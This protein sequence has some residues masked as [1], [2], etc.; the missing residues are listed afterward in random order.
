MAD[1]HGA[2]F[3][4]QMAKAARKHWA[5]LTVV[6][7]DA[8]DLLDTPLGQA[9]VRQR[10]HPNPAAPSPPNHRPDRRHLRPVRRR[11]VL[12]ARR[13]AR[14]RPARGRHHPHRLHRP[15][16]P[17]RTPTHHHQPRRT[18][19][20]RRRPTAS[21]TATSPNRTPPRKPLL[22]KKE[23]CPLSPVADPSLPPVAPPSPIP[24]PHGL[25]AHFLENPGRELHH[26][27]RQLLAALH[28]PAPA[29][30]RS[31]P[32]LLAAAAAG[33]AAGSSGS[34]R[35][36][37]GGRLIRLH[38]PPT[39]DP[40]GALTFWTNLIAL[41][42]PGWKRILF[43]QPHVALRNRRHRRRFG[44]SA[45]GARSGSAGDGRTGRRS[46]LARR[47]HQHHTR[48]TATAR[49]RGRRRV[50]GCGWPA[51]TACR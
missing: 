27:A 37:D 16:L 45:L 7:Q 31:P 24:T 10:R 22:R 34:A 2:K 42:R 44:V 30:C 29:R 17:R 13:P 41:L 8:A 15:R 28:I 35:L 26:L 38:A 36:A 6:T 5:G 18:R 46:R 40:A 1:P 48:H 19:H 11:T 23:P 49:Q 32:L 51:P 21:T 47:P 39:V 33:R 50:G 4:F 3:L 14:R 12:P 9:V 25:L 20:H 43:G